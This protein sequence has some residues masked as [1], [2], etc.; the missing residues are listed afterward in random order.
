MIEEKKFTKRVR[1][2][3]KAKNRIHRNGT[4]SSKHIRTKE[5]CKQFLSLSPDKQGDKQLPV[6]ATCY[7]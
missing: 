5:R 6:K 7:S 3:D 4:Y 2:K 1:G